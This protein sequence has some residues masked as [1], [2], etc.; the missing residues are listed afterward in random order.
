MGCMFK[1]GDRVKLKT[2]LSSL[3]GVNWVINFVRHSNRN[4]VFT[5]SNV[6][7]YEDSFVIQLCRHIGK[8]QEHYWVQVEAF[9][10]YY[11]DW[12]DAIPVEVSYAK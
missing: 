3:A 1:E 2:D 8:C 4:G 11:E 6:T 5:V 12:M 7:T 9:E 10:P